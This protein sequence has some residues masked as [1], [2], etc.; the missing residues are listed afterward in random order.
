MK[1]LC[2]IGEA[3][4]DFIPNEKGR[5]LKD[6][7][8]FKQVAGGAPANV[9]GAVAKLGGQSVF[10]TKLGD[11]AF[12][13]V[14]VD[15][16][17]KS[18]ID[19]QYILRTKEYDT[20]LAFVS[21]RLDGNRDFKFYR[22]TAADLQFQP[23]DIDLAVLEDVGFIHFCSVSL[24]DSPMKKA[25]LRLIEVANEKNIKICFDPN[26]RLSLWDD[27]EELKKT[28][29]EFLPYAHCIK[30][31]DEELEFITGYTNIKDALPL[32]FKNKCEYL[33]YT[34]GKDGV[35]LY[36]KDNRE[37]SVNGL[38]V[39]VVDTTGAGD[40]F[41]GSFLYK[42]LNDDIEQLLSVSNETLHEYLSFANAYAALTT[43]KEGALAAMATKIEFEAFYTK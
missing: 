6:V 5:R 40:S 12:G 41:I 31:S 36:T 11:D 9:C 16:L 10:L 14:I 43:T 30:I 32:F 35:T 26:L 25:H 7:E 22:R 17:N 33:L 21:L 29:L 38:V 2:G 42:L 37:I 4:I 19:T 27:A 24:V 3:L 1:K 18:E 8:N 39:D 28:V 13:D 34:K 23:D 15:E 20:S